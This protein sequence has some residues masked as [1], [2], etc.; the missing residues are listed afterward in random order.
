M[1][2]LNNLLDKIR[3]K[4]EEKHIYHD[5]FLDS[6]FEVKLLPLKEF[7]NIVSRAKG[8]DGDIDVITEILYRSVPIFQ[9]E[10]LLEEL[11]IKVNKFSVVSTIFNQNLGAMLKFFNYI[12]GLYGIDIEKEDVQEKK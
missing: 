12:N 1:S 8:K 2:N 6:D 3:V 11:N 5:D 10:E 9:E 4:K 7:M